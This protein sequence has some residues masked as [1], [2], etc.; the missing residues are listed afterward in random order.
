MIASGRIPATSSGIISGVGLA[1]A[2][3]NG[4]FAILEI[5]DLETNPPLERPRKTSASL[6]ASPTVPSGISNAN[7]ALYS[8]RSPTFSLALVIM[9]PESHMIKLSGFTPNRI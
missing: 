7:L 9:P 2:K 1:N 3:T 5:I 8:L 6:I 4:S